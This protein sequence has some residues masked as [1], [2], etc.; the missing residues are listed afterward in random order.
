MAVLTLDAK[1]RDVVFVTERYWLIRTLPL[2]GYPWG[3]LQLIQRYSQR[4]HYQSRQDQAHTR[5]SV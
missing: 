4:N 3:A 1:A 2:P 5:E